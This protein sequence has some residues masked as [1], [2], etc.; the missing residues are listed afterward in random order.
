MGKVLS[1]SQLYDKIVNEAV[2][3]L[4]TYKNS[5]FGVAWA[6]PAWGIAA[7]TGY[8]KGAVFV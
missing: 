8:T 3:S 1:S 2:A 7:G 5:P 4:Y 6:F